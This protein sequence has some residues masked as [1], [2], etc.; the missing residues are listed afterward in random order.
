MVKCVLCGDQRKKIS[1]INQLPVCKRHYDRVLN[2]TSVFG[3][4]G[5][6]VEKRSDV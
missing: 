6:D 1:Y 5:I 4:T 2:I 3:L